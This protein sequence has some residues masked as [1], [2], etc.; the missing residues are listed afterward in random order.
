MNYIKITS[1]E[2]LT[3]LCT[4]FPLECFISLNGGLRSRKNIQFEPSDN[5]FHI[6]NW[7]DKT[8]QELTAEELFTES[9]IGE[10]ISKG[11]FWTDDEEV[12]LPT[13]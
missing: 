1:V 2:M 12:M 11:S 7:I 3:K 10:A 6:D 8:R 13:T 5:K 4:E 9:N